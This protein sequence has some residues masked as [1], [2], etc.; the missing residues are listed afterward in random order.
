MATWLEVLVYVTAGTAGVIAVVHLVRDRPAEDGMYILLGVIE[1]LLLLQVV[2]GS[3]ALAGT[4]R[5]VSG[6]L[7]VSY[8]IGAA[9]VLPIGAFWSLAERT[10]AGTAVLLLAILTVIALEL[11]L[12]DIWAG[13]GA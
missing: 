11:R 10:R 2:L 13:A 5:D 8:L 4:E 12:A 3:V 1:L 9:L 6:A 7:F